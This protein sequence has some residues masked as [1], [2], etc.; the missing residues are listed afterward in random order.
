M[1]TK[2]TNGLSDGFLSPTSRRICDI[3]C[4]HSPKVL[5]IAPVRSQFPLHQK[6]QQPQ[7]EALVVQRKVHQHRFQ[8]PTFRSKRRLHPALYP[9][10]HHTRLR[11]WQRTIGLDQ[12][13]S[14]LQ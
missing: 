9:A 8:P 5:N 3:S 13:P 12:V 6:A 7:I 14:Q 11:H 4:L 2:Q 10:L 1:G